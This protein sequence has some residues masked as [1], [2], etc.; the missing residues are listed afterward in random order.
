LRRANQHGGGQQVHIVSPS[1]Y[2]TC[3]DIEADIEAIADVV[4]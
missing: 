3:A 1:P 2:G 4:A